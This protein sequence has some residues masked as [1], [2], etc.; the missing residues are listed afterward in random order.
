MNIPFPFNKVQRV[1]A[2]FDTDFAWYNAICAFATLQSHLPHDVT[3][4]LK[5]SSEL[6]VPPQTQSTGGHTCHLSTWSSWSSSTV[7][8]HPMD[9]VTW[10]EF[11]NIHLHAKSQQLTRKAREWLRS[12]LSTQTHQG[13]KAPWGSQH[14]EHLYSQHRF[15]LRKPAKWRTQFCEW[16]R[17]TVTPS[18]DTNCLQL[19]SG[20]LEIEGL[21][22]NWRGA[23]PTPHE[24]LYL[25]LSQC[26]SISKFHTLIAYISYTPVLNL[27]R[28]QPVTCPCMNANLNLCLT[29]A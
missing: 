7:Q 1:P 2:A 25:K 12:G 10:P 4:S 13:I 22:W 24:N 18:S 27:C 15:R 23:N 20:V 29:H 9:P 11:E 14:L 21:C 8:G 6:P 19:L 26:S 5:H 17:M 16:G 28:P 3:S